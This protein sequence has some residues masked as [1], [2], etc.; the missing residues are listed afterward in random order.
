MLAFALHSGR[1]SP[2]KSFP[3]GR[4]LAR[5]FSSNGSCFTLVG[6]ASSVEL[7]LGFEDLER[8][9]TSHKEVTDDSHRGGQQLP[10]FSVR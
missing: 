10:S 1:P 2:L 7:I 3:S 9:D 8:S 5:A 6:C 4:K